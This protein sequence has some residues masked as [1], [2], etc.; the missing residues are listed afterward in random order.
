M[1]TGLGG[2]AGYGENSFKTTGVDTGNLDDGSISVDITSVFGPA[3]INFYSTNYTSIFINSNGLITFDG[4]NIGYVPS[5]ISSLAEPAIAPF[6]TDI[7][8]T[9]GGDIY[10][11]IDPVGGNVTI[12]WLD[13]AP[14]ASSGT[15]SFQLVLSDLGGGD[16]GIE[17]IYEDI[18]YAD[19]GTD[20]A[21]ATAGITDGGTNDI[22]LSG[23]GNEAAMLAYESNDFGKGDPVGTYTLSVT[24]GTPPCFVAGTQI[25]TPDGPMR[26]EDIKVEQLV[27]TRDHGQQVVLW[28]GGR[29]YVANPLAKHLRPV[30]IR[31]GALGNRQTLRVSQQHAF[32]IGGQLIRARHLAEFCGGQVAR[33]DRQAQQVSYHHVLTEQHTFI[34]AHGAWAET[35]YPGPNV[36]RLLGS[37][38]YLKLIAAAPH[39]VKPDTYGPPAL[40]YASRFDL[41]GPRSPLQRGVIRRGSPDRVLHYAGG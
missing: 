26:I 4:P 3:G 30:I 17:F 36:A 11:D 1:N 10:W 25:A 5:G 12:T 15:N 23:S 16:F 38:Q 8:I 9:S 35:L 2:G 41:R 31:K 22:D 29:N 6:W 21:I 14:F 28:V 40:P 7:D 34:S 19:G 13:V 18:Q 32:P 24:S 39:A 20:P 27:L 37:R 33:F